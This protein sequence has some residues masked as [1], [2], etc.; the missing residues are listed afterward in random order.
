MCEPE[1]VEE[2]ST[3]IYLLLDKAG[4][5]LQGDVRGSLGGM[6]GKGLDG[7]LN[8]VFYLVSW[9]GRRRFL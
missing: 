4:Q 3:E 7:W 9:C 8:S 1:S 6:K 5:G 2:K